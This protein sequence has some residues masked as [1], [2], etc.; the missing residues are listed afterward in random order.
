MPSEEEGVVRSVAASLGT[1]AG[2]GVSSQPTQEDMPAIVPIRSSGL[3]TYLCLGQLLSRRPT[4]EL[5][6]I[7]LTPALTVIAF[8]LLLRNMILAMFIMHAIMLLG[9][10]VYLMGNTSIRA[11]LRNSSESTP[12]HWY[13]VYF[14]SEMANTFNGSGT[15]LL[16]LLS[17]LVTT[18]CGSLIYL[19]LQ[20]SG[21]WWQI[22]CIGSYESQLDIFGLGGLR[23]TSLLFDVLLALYFIIVNPLIEEFF[24]R[25]FL[26]KE[27]S[28]SSQNSHMGRLQQ[29]FSPVPT[30]EPQDR[31]APTGGD[32]ELDIEVG[33]A[34]SD[35]FMDEE[36]A[37]SVSS[38]V[39]SIS[40]PSPAVSASNSSRLVSYSETVNWVGSALYG[41]YHILV[42]WALLNSLPYAIL[43]F[44]L[45]VLVGRL[46]IFIIQSEQGPNASISGFCLATAVHSGLDTVVV[47]ALAAALRIVEVKGDNTSVV[48]AAANAGFK[49]IKKH[50]IVSSMYI[51]GLIVA[52]FG[53]GFHV[54]PITAARYHKTL[55]HVD[56][57]QG[58]QYRTVVQKLDRAERDYYNSWF[59]CNDECQAKYR[60]VEDL[61]DQKAVVESKIYDLQLDAKKTVGLWSSYAAQDMRKDFW[62]VRLYY[63][64]ILMEWLFNVNHQ[65][66]NAGKDMASHWTLWDTLFMA[67][68]GD[69][70]DQTLMSM[71]LQTVFQ[72]IMNLTVGLIAAIGA[73]LTTVPQ[74]IASYGP[75]FIEGV[76][77]F[78]LVLCAAAAAVVSFLGVIYGGVAGGGYYLIKREIDRLEADPQQQRYRQVRYGERGRPHYE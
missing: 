76:V 56:L 23:H 1:P 38:M 60:K 8:G 2:L 11:G 46:L 39:A 32:A 77:Y 48:S 19:M 37:R 67:A 28:D 10:T 45:L 36:T 52:V 73:F 43:A 71:I 3:S 15:V 34:R 72:Y 57:V 4:L 59:S 55:D 29:E 26:I 22:L 21:R 24:W 65:S 33:A 27:L 61:R 64:L 51:I 50:Y 31:M 58:R 17:F 5:V 75:G 74:V 41:S 53:T 14:S 70:R 18:L 54:D 63:I 47:F 66:W 35:V 7:G 62:D 40:P 42:V 49:F 30:S 78:F 25:I 16:S 13:R 20:C 6:L 9:P 44:I 68:G 12:P 69:P